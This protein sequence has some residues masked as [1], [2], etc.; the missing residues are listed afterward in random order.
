MI[1]YGDI[2]VVYI[3]IC[4]YVDIYIQNN[5]IETGVSTKTGGIHPLRQCQQ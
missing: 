1:L 3:Y 4:M 2:Y 5:N